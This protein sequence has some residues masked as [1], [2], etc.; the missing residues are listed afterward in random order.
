MKIDSIQNGI[1]LDHISSGRSM[2]I[3]HYLG[4][5]KID[6][7]VA[8]IKNVKSG[9]RGKKDIIKID[10]RYDVNF[11]IIGYVDP[12]ITVSIIENGKTTE[13]KKME[14]PQR[15]VNI[16]KCKNPRCITREEPSIDH[17]FELTDKEN[18]VY[19]CVYCET[20]SE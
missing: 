8:I 16:V 19:R 13:K 17:M 12:D 9:K 5:D 7:S 20:V 3:Y 18:K 14:L 15:I 11:D 6:D 10:G 1:V 2:E 4:L